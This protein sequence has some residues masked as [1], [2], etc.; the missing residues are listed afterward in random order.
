VHP[1]LDQLERAVFEPD[2]TGEREHVEQLELV[3]EVVL[4]PEQHR[5]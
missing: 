2:V 5:P 3:V 4:E 1:R